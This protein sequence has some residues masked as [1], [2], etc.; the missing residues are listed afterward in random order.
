MLR[1]SFGLISGAAARSSAS[2]SS[3]S[4]AVA[5]PAAL[6]LFARQYTE[7]ATQAEGASSVQPGQ[8]AHAPS[9][10][11]QAQ[12]Q[13]KGKAAEGNQDL[14]K[15]L[16]A[17]DHEI[18]K[19]KDSWLRSVA[20]FENLQ[21]I[22]QREKT[23]AKDYAI[24]SFAKDIIDSMDILH[25]ALGTVPADKRAKA[26]SASSSGATPNDADHLSDLFIGVDMT[27]RNLEKTLGRFGVVAF[28]P[29]GEKFD[30]NRHEAMYQAPIPGKEPGSVLEC[31][32]KGWLL[33]DRLLRPAQVG[34]VMDS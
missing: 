30:P 7:A 13:G 24:E 16:E 32:K 10:D 22:T 20:E 1:Q 9:S 23:K 17:K 33:K 11:K 26:S 4:A 18:A 5:S 29:T 19:L 14:Q 3:S 25:L 27:A 8:E 12:A 31:Q 2:T 6:R 34:V 21:K 15:A 28:D